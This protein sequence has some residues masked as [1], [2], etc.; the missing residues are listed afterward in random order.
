M[1]KSKIV[2]F[3]EA[4]VYIPVLLTLQANGNKNQRYSYFESISLALET[5]TTSSKCSSTYTRCTL[6]LIKNAHFFTGVH[7]SLFI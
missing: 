5:V 7:V 6:P 1:K 4:L 3:L 2:L